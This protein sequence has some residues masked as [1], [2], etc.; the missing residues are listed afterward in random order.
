MDYEER[1]DFNTFHLQAFAVLALISV[2]AG[3]VLL[4]I[5]MQRLVRVEMA[6]RKLKR[7]TPQSTQS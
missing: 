2:L 5:R 4:I 7:S 6:K 3:F 1:E